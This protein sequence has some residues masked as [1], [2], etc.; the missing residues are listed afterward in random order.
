MKQFTGKV[1]S[2]KMN[3][4]A[5][6]EITIVKKHP[7]YGRSSVIKRNLKAHINDETIK[8]GDMVTAFE[9]RPISKTKQ[10]IIKK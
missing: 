8:V 9:V 4:T 3:K 6:V 5:V 10:F 1:L 2:L 7:I